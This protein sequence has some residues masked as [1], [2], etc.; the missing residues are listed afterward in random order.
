MRNRPGAPEPGARRGRRRRAHPPLGAIARAPGTGQDAIRRRRVGSPGALGGDDD[1]RDTRVPP[2]RKVPRLCRVLDWFEPG[3]TRWEPNARASG[4]PS[5]ERHAH[6]SRGR[7]PVH[8][9]RLATV[10]AHHAQRRE[11]VSG[12]IKPAG[13]GNRQAP[14]RPSRT[15]PS[16][17]V[18]RSTRASSWPSMP[19][20][21]HRLATPVELVRDVKAG[22]EREA[23]RVEDPGLV[24]HGLDPP[25]QVLR[26]AP[27]CTRA[28]RAREPTTADPGS[29]RPLAPRSSA[30]SFVRVPRSGRGPSGCP[31][32]GRAAAGAPRGVA[33]A[34]PRAGR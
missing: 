12:L 17:S 23:Q 9:T 10:V 16:R 7:T 28:C 22:Q 34:P 31:P 14:A 6:R 20:R 8:D 2:I 24:P 30:A 1:G 15:A 4:F 3:F 21:A 25:A 32:P 19:A 26:P 5:R 33:A 11:A 29:R 27:G 13:P 18:N